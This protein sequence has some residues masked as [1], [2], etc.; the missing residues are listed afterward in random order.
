MSALT[1]V[2]AAVISDMNFHCFVCITP[3]NV[4]FLLER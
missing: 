2:I 1:S 4:V 3:E